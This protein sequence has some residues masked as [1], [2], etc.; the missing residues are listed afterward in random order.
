MNMWNE[1]P[2][3]WM[4]VTFKAVMVINDKGCF[5]AR[6]LLRRH[7]NQMQYMILSWDLDN[8]ANTLWNIWQILNRAYRLDDR[9]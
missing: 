6:K 8:E 9:T 2:T 7:D 5:P 4:P 3:G 1:H